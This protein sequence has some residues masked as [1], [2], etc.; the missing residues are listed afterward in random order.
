[1]VISWFC[2]REGWEE[3]CGGDGLWEVEAIGWWIECGDESK[4]RAS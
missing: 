3:G 4:I 2:T 1:M